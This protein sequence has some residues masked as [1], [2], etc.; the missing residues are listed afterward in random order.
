MAPRTDWNPVLREELAQPYWAELQAFVDA[1]RS[2]HEVYPPS[3][4]VFAALHQTPY[5]GVKVVILGQ[6]PYHGPGQ[7]HG[8]AFSVSDTVPLPIPIECPRAVPLDSWHM[9]EQSGRL[10]V[11]SARTRSW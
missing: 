9:F 2:R 1:E 10:L 6:D 4:Q 8:L 5:A 7:A 11:P 3:E